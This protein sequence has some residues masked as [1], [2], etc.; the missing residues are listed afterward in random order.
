MTLDKVDA[1][2]ITLNK[3]KKEKKERKTYHAIRIG[4]LLIVYFRYSEDKS[5]ISLSNLLT[6]SVPDVGYSR[7]PSCAL[8]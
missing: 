5:I 1:N 4:M 2:D 8:N 7:N 6:L 3:M